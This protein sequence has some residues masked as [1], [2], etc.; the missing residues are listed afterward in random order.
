MSYFSRLSPQ[1]LSAVFL[2]AG[3]C[4]GGGML[5][6]PVATCV[7]GF[8]PSLFV[9]TLAWL[10]MTC[11]ALYLVEAGFWMKKDEAHL[12]SMTSLLLGKGGKALSWV[13]YLFICYASLVAYTAGAGHL[14]AKLIT[15]YGGLELSKSDGCLLFMALFGPTIFCSHKALGRL[16]SILFVAMI[17]AYVALITLSAPHINQELLFRQQWDGSWMALPL[18]LTA[19]SFQTMVP[20]LHPYLNH[21]GRSLRV[22]II[23]GSTIAFFVYLIW[24]MAVLGTVSLEGPFG[25]FQA[26]KEGEVATHVLGIAVGSKWVEF[27]ASFFAI[28]ALVTSFFGISLGLYDFLSDGLNIPKKGWG[29][30][31]L[32]LMIIAPTLFFSINFE[33]IFLTALD[34][35]GG[36]GDAILNGILPVLMIYIGRY[37]M[38]LQKTSFV[39]PG[40]KWLLVTL[41]AFYAIALIIEV[42]THTGHLT[43]IHDVKEFLLN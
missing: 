38:K 39:A 7:N 8:F 18:L 21:D 19:F 43:A 13:L 31:T 5:A 28:F 17:I 11:T 9:I 23:G 16:N 41:F 20:S 34:A 4:T 12:I 1:T 27:L 14:M 2:V 42:L 40:G 30:A 35:S 29:T 6:L 32:G 10:A 26:L 37:Y 33:R 24:Q 36:F 25:L 15:F 3:T 22:A